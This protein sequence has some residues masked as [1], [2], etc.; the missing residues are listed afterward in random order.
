MSDGTVIAGIEQCAE[1]LDEPTIVVLSDP[2]EEISVPDIHIVALTYDTG[3]NRIFGVTRGAPG[4]EWT[5]DDG[6]IL[7][8]DYDTYEFSI[9][10]TDINT[11]EQV[12]FLDGVVYGITME[13]N[14]LYYIPID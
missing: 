13:D 10:E 6:N 12:A 14:K 4:L 9:I 8:W 1:W 2:L 11:L 5:P 7:V 3:S